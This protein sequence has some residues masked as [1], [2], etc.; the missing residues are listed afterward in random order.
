MSIKLVKMGWTQNCTTYLAGMTLAQIESRFRTHGIKDD[1]GKRF[2][3]VTQVSIWHNLKKSNVADK[4][5]LVE[6][7]DG[8]KWDTEI[9]YQ[10]KDV[11]VFVSG[12]TEFCLPKKLGSLSPKAKKEWKRFHGK[13]MQHEKQHYTDGIDVAKKFV[14]Q[15]KSA[16]MKVKVVYFDSGQPDHWTEL[17]KKARGAA[18]AIDGN[19]Q[20]LRSADIAYAFSWRDHVSRHGADKGARLN[21]TIT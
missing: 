9:A 5:E 21:T 1:R 3:A 2:P 20:T 12:H 7:I 13:L 11:T 10:F 4:I 16:R 6:E 17:R 8:E 14:Q 18:L 19:L 15:M